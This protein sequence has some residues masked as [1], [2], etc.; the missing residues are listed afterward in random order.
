MQAI[1]ELIINDPRHGEA[2]H[3]VCTNVLDL[4][5][6][7][8]DRM[9][10]IIDRGQIHMVC[11]A[12]YCVSSF[13]DGLEHRGA[14]EPSLAGTDRRAR[15][16]QLSPWFRQL[17]QEW[18]KAISSSSLI[19]MPQPWPDLDDPAVCRLVIGQFIRSYARGGAL[20]ASAP[21]VARLMSFKGGVL[22]LHELMRR[23]TLPASEQPRRF[24]RRAFAQRLGLSR[25][26]V[27]D[28]LAAAAEH[29]LII[30]ADGDIAPTPAMLN[31]GRTWLTLHLAAIIRM[32]QGE[33]G[34][35]LRTATVPNAVENVLPYQSLSGFA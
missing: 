34:D 4:Y 3:G 21:L 28:L 29:D 2:M 12:Y 16:R 17:I 13:L 7:N 33:L 5:A 23:A 27:I 18:L 20:L 10:L 14:L 24:S 11:G 31:E 6:R 8:P 26:Q 32:M 19:W 25:T 22:L 1:V 15:M 9:G 30:E 35:E